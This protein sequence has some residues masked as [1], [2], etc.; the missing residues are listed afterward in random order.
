[1]TSS[2]TSRS[3][4]LMLRG[5]LVDHDAHRAFGRMRAHVDQAARETLVL[6]APAWRSASARRESRAP[7]LVPTP[8]CSALRVIRMWKGYSDRPDLGIKTCHNRCSFTSMSVACAA[9]PH[10]DH[11]HVC[12]PSPS[13]I[14][15]RSW[16]R[17][18][19]S[20]RHPSAIAADVSPWDDDL[21]SAARL[22]PRG[23]I[24]NQAAACSAPASRSGSSQA[25]RP[26]GAIRAIPAC[27]RASISPSRKTSKPS[28]VR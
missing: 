4:K 7:A 25:G 19:C 21:Q 3:G 16:P 5:R 26:I 12:S 28:T 24:T 1:M 17:Q 20:A 27:R 15:C 23:R 14:Y 11:R 10:L 22:M 2:C 6:H 9:L 18:A 8:F 13:L